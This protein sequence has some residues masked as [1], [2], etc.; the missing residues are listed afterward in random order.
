MG[1]Y[2]RFRYQYRCI[3]TSL[4]CR[5]PPPPPVHVALPSVA[6]LTSPDVS[7]SAITGWNSFSALT[8]LHEEEE[9]DPPSPRSTWHKFSRRLQISQHPKH[10]HFQG[11]PTVPDQESELQHSTTTD[12][13]Q[14]QDNLLN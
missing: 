1:R 3:G 10:P 7:Y 11:T 12:V 2:R 14:P 13:H 5:T 8:K 9:V 6:T 4:L